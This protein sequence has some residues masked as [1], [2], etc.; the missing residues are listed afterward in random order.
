MRS[1]DAI[2]QILKDKGVG[3]VQLA[4]RLGLEPKK[5][6][7]ISQRFA[8]DNITVCKLM[9]MLRVLDYKI[10]LVP[11]NARLPEGSYEI[12]S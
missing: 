9:E 4:M 2:K 12:E 7:V 6:N 8:R 5:S 1:A 10:V 3:V 11:S